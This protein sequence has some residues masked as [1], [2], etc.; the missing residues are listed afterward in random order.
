MWL[1][2]AEVSG[3]EAWSCAHSFTYCSL[4]SAA[5]VLQRRTYSLADLQASERDL[6]VSKQ[7]ESLET[8]MELR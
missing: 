7:I 3:V 8:E 1:L 4:L 6:S 2:F 5:A